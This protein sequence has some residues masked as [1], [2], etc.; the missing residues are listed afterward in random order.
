MLASDILHDLVGSM[1]IDVVVNACHEVG[2]STKGNRSLYQLL[3]DCLCQKGIVSNILPSPKSLNTR[4]GVCNSNV[5]D[6]IGE[7]HHFNGTICIARW[8]K[9]KSTLG[10]YSFEYNKFNKIFV[11]L[12]ML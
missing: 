3:G 9:K 6:K 4:K 7:Y 2:I 11:D 12:R 8:E 5:I 10:Q 1:S